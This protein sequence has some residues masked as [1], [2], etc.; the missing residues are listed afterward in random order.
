LHEL[1]Q[2][3]KRSFQPAAVH[4]TSD[5][6]NLVEANLQPLFTPRVCSPTVHA[7]LSAF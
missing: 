5:A 7:A 3:E 6:A 4:A 2:V 1:Q